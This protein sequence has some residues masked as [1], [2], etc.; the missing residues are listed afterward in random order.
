MALAAAFAIAGY[1]QG[2]IIGVLSFAGFAGRTVLGIIL[3]PDVAMAVTKS[4]NLQAVLAI[5][6]VFASAVIGMLITSAI[7]VSLRARV[8]RRP[9]TVLDSLGG[10]V[11]NV[12]A[13]LLL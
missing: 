3:A 4:Q 9:S 10:S 11:V 13:I 5:V 8:R 12:V 2:F 1:R 7:G 6:L